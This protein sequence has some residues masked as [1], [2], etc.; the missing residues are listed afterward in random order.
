MGE[1]LNKID[2][3]G[4]MNNTVVIMFGDHGFELY[5]HGGFEYLHII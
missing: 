3:F 4:L 1:L 5:E 2:K